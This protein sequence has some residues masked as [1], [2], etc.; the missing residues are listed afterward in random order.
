MGLILVITGVNLVWYQDWEL[1]YFLILVVFYALFR[2]ILPKPLWP[3]LLT[4]LITAVLFIHYGALNLTGIISYISLAI[5]LYSVIR[6]RMLRQ[7][8]HEQNLRL[9]GRAAEGV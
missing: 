9:Y 7:E 8:M 1:V 6:R 5:L 2:L 3:A 4:L